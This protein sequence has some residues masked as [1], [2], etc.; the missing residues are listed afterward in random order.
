M[1]KILQFKKSPPVPESPAI[2]LTDSGQLTAEAAEI[3][4][5]W[6]MAK[7]PADTLQF[8]MKIK[9]ILKSHEV[10]IS[11]QSLL[12]GFDAVKDFTLEEL[13]LMAK[14]ETED[15]WVDSPGYYTALSDAILSKIFSA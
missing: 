3:E 14:Q 10:H 9:R 11:E 5:A 12:S 15:Q 2:A 6:E 1:G 7:S 13:I 8:A 4:K